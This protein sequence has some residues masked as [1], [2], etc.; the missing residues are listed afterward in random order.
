[1]TS[2]ISVSALQIKLAKPAL[3]VK[4][5]KAFL[6]FLA[7]LPFAF[8]LVVIAT[9]ALTAISATDLMGPQTVASAVMLMDAD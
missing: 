2:Q 7:R 4:I 3:M 1:M 6:P 5:M 9:M 8:A